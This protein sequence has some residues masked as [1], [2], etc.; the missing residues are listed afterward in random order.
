MAGAGDKEDDRSMETGVTDE[1][2]EQ[3]EKSVAQIIEDVCEDI[4][5]NYCKY[6]IHYDFKDDFNYDRIWEEHCNKCPLNK[7]H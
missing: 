3:A 5:D 1:E 2:F 7:L 6:P 4:C